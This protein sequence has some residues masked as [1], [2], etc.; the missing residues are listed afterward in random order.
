MHDLGSGTLIDLSR[1]GLS[2]EPTVREAV[3]RG[4]QLVTFSGD[5][6]LGGPQ[7]GVI[8]GAHALIEKIRDNPLRR[9]LRI[10]KIRL[11]ALEATLKLYR[12]PERL[13]EH[14]P[15][16]KFL[17]RSQAEIA[18]TAQ[19]LRAE[20]QKI[21]GDAFSVDVE[22]CSS[23]VGS[24]AL[25]LDSLPSAGFFIFSKAGRDGRPIEQLAAALRQLPQPVIGRIENGRLVLDLRC[26]TEPRALLAALSNLEVEALPQSSAE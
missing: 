6:L 8:V 1:Y 25:P 3:A 17:H 18:A 22:S 5:K 20:V 4:A 11:A 26:L 10:D 16:L 12:D 21:L 23:E 13:V 2:K 14:V 24:G 9:A 7:A 15:T 19:G